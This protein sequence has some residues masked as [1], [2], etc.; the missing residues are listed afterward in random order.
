MKR[1]SHWTRCQ[2][3]TAWVLKCASWSTVKWVC[4]PVQWTSAAKLDFQKTTWPCKSQTALSTVKVDF[5]LWKLPFNPEIIC[6]RRHW[7]LQ[8]PSLPI[9]NQNLSFKCQIGRSVVRF[10]LSESH[11][12]RI[13]HMRLS[14]FTLES[15]LHWI[16]KG[17]TSLSMI[18]M[19]FWQSRLR[20][21]GRRCLSTTKSNVPQSIWRSNSQIQ[22]SAITCM[23]GAEQTHVQEAQFVSQNLDMPANSQTGVSIIACLFKMCMSPINWTLESRSSFAPAK[24]DYQ[25]LNL[26]FNIQQSQNWP[27]T[28]HIGCAMVK[29]SFE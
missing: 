22:C 29:L 7:V 6:S 4:K 24:L 12:L 2:G 8:W 14:P 26:Q 19:N 15:K 5:Q 25:M 20:S 17:E 16:L 3:Q 28:R 27:S 1:Y 9:D 18:K 23:I 10:D 11:R 21:D 13:N